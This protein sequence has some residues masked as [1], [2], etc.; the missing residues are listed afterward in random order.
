MGLILLRASPSPHPTMSD[1]RLRA[2][3][4]AGF[5]SLRSSDFDRDLPS[6]K[7]ARAIQSL[8]MESNHRARAYETRLLQGTQR[9]SIWLRRRDLHA[10]P[11]AHEADELA[12]AP[13]RG[14]LGGIRTRTTHAKVSLGN[15]LP[16]IAFRAMPGASAT[17][18]PPH[19]AQPFPADVA[20]RCS[21]PSKFMRPVSHG[22]SFSFQV[23]RPLAKAWWRLTRIELASSGCKPEAL[24]LSYSPVVY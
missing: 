9:K 23:A 21:S 19:L 18:K 16:Y 3:G 15:S 13:L 6:P 11:S 8:R 7:S 4:L 14:A 2:P 5:R 12:T 20:R 10:R 22:T 17:L 24:P 1:E